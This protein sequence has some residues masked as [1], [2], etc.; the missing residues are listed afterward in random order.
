MSDSQ[1]RPR[2]PV[3]WATLLLGSA[4]LAGCGVLYTGVATVVPEVQGRHTDDNVVIRA[5]TSGRSSAYAEKFALMALFSKVVYRRDLGPARL[6]QDRNCHAYPQPDFGMPAG[7]QRWQGTPERPDLGCRNLPSGLFL[8]VYAHRS[9]GL[10]D[11]LV[12]AYRGTENQGLYQFIV[13][14]KSNL[15]ALF[16]FE[17]S[18]YQDAQAHLVDMAAALTAWKDRPAHLAIYA[19][20][21]SLGGGLA[22]QAGYFWNEVKEVFAFD[23]SVVTN[24]TWLSL[25]NRVRNPDPIVHRIF[26]SG[27]ALDYARRI[28]SRVNTQLLGRTDYE[29]RYQTDL[30]GAA[31]RHEMGLLA[32]HMTADL[33]R[34]SIG[35]ASPKVAVPANH[36]YTGEAARAVFCKAG[37]PDKDLCPSSVHVPVLKDWCAANGAAAV[38]VTPTA[39]DAK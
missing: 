39:G 30:R 14:W 8:E 2:G 24:W 26:H 38:A 12:I 27:E 29:I 16:G 11:E 5:Y 31:E 9:Q 37:E 33:M 13:D 6:D 17:P 20:G 4:L 32:C 3:G 23:P 28:T 25:R 34:D 1:A 15:A 22:Q 19:T 35:A 7:W 36:W 18:Q 21:H 10:T